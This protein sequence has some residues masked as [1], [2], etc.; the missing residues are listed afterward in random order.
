MSNQYV[1][2]PCM[3]YKTKFEHNKLERVTLQQDYDDGT[4]KKKKCPAFSGDT[5]LKPYCLWKIVLT[6]FVDNSNSP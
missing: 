3:E 1:R 6:L 2:K 4:Y 5:E